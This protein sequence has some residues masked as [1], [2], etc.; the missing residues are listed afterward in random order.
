[1][2]HP[3]GGGLAEWAMTPGASSYAY[4]SPGAEVR[5]YNA[6][7]GG[8]RVADLSLDPDGVNV[9]GSVTAG[10]DGQIPVFYGPDGVT[11]LWLSANN[12]PRTKAIT[13]DGGARLDAAAATL[14][15][16][17]AQQ[18][19][20]EATEGEANGIGT[21]GADGTLT[22][23]QA[24]PYSL[25]GS[26]DVNADG[27]SDGDL[28]VRSGSVWI[29]SHATSPYPTPWAALALLSGNSP[30]DSI[31]AY[32]FIDPTTVQL[33][34][35]FTKNTGSYD[36]GNAVA[37]LP[38]EITPAINWYGMGGTGDS[39]LPMRIRISSTGQIF[40]DPYEVTSNAVALDGI[41]Y[42]TA[43]GLTNAPVTYTKSW[44]ATW[45]QTYSS[46]NGYLGGNLCYQGNSGVDGRG[47]QRSLIGWDSAAIRAEIEG[48]VMVKIV[49]SLYFPHWWYSAGGTACI[50]THN[51]LSAPTF[52]NG[53]NVNE[54]RWTSAN[55]PRHAW[56]DIVLPNSVAGEFADGDSTGIALGPAPS[57]SLT[58]Y[59]YAYGA[60]DAAKPYI[61]ITYTK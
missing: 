53:N 2:R 35:G 44:T 27:V 45:S 43:Y 39:D 7:T 33:R 50:G 22:P 12:G 19:A 54:R 30:L 58:Y 1:M 28:L 4:V 5:A 57:N 47:N 20:L 36:Y 34:G 49:L 59:G 15:D 23:G 60:Y 56:R 37:N 29:P 31:P 38:E 25:V 32:R 3:F 18:S 11:A 51:Y 41:L 48:A 40:T 10:P 46:D 26:D 14:A 17:T 16:A 24:P 8:V 55:W 21:L 6:P 13:S 42:D 9:V 61:T 52:W